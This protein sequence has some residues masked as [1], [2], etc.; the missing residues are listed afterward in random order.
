MQPRVLLLGLACIAG[1]ATAQVQNPPHPFTLMPPSQPPVTL[2]PPPAPA[3]RV[4]LKS[5]ETQPGKQ[6]T[7]DVFYPCPDERGRNCT[8]KETYR[9]D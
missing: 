6:C 3:P 2:S 4:D 8:R 1:A 7:R 5:G 9:C